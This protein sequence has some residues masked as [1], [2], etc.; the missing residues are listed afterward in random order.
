MLRLVF[1]FHLRPVQGNMSLL[2]WVE[3]RSEDGQRS[4]GMASEKGD[5][6]NQ[7]QFER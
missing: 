3:S 5:R 6:S 7:V 2:R 1:D 4:A